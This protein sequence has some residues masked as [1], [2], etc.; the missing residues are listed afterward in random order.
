MYTHV[1]HVELDAILS[2][3]GEESKGVGGV[4]KKSNSGARESEER[5]VR[6]SWSLPRE[7]GN[8]SCGW[9]LGTK[10]NK[11]KNNK[12]TAAVT[13]AVTFPFNKVAGIAGLECSVHVL[14]IP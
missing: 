5:R 11:Q 12:S 1:K 9:R 8:G 6:A 10:T 13:F 3:S 7:E 14:L 4:G 2:G